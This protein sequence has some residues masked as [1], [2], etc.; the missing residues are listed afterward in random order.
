MRY[1]G[2]LKMAVVL[3]VC[4]KKLCGG[5][6]S[7][8]QRGIVLTKHS[9]YAVLDAHTSDACRISAAFLHSFDLCRTFA[10][11]T[12]ALFEALHMLGPTLQ[13]YIPVRAPLNHAKAHKEYS[14][15]S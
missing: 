14:E 13:V 10:R 12:G 4:I 1:T 8:P 3:L 2:V 6:A 7:S 9:D 5:R 15:P 11:L